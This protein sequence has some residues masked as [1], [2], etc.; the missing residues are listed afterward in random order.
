MAEIDYW[1]GKLITIR[2]INVG[3]QTIYREIFTQ[4]RTGSLPAVLFLWLAAFFAPGTLTAQDE[5]LNVLE[6][7]TEWSDAK[8]MLMRHL[9]QQAFEFLDRRDAAI[10]G[11]VSEADWKARQ[12]SVRET[13]LKTVGPFP[14]KTPLNARITGTLKEEGFRIEKVMYESMPGFPV[15]GCLYIPDGRGKKPAILFVS[16]HTNEAFRYPSYQ[17]M[18]LNLVKKGFIV[19][20]I[21]PVSQGERIQILDPEKHTSA[22]GPTTR[23]HNHLG[24]QTFLSGVSLARYFIWDGIRAVD[25]LLT[26]KEADPDRIGITGQSG[27]GTQTACIFAFDDRIKAAAVVNYITGFRR[28]LES[29]GP[30][31]AEQNFN[32]GIING[33]THADLLEVRAPAP[34]LISAG[35]RD[36]FSIQGARETFAE[37]RKT[38]AAFGKT[39]NLRMEEDDFGHGY[40]PL[41][42]EGIYD[43]FRTSLDHECLTKDEEVSVM[44][45]KA[46]WVT[47]SG[48][49][50]SSLE[51]IETVFTLNK[52]EA[53]QLLERLNNS[54]KEGKVHLDRVLTAAKTLSGYQEPETGEDPVFRGRYRR[55]GYSVEMYALKG[56]GRCVIPLLLFVPDGALKLPSMVWLH[57]QGKAVDARPGGRMEQLVKKGYVVAAPDLSG[58]GEVENSSYGAD[59]LSFMIGRSITG[60]QSGDAARVVRFLEA[61]NEVDNNRIEGVAF[62]EM[63]PVLLHAAAFTRKFS[64]ITLMGSLVSYGSVAMERLYDARFVNQ[65]VAGA[66]AAYDLPDLAASLAPANLRL[67]NPMAGNGK[68]TDSDDHDLRYLVSVYQAEAPEG[69]IQM[70]FRLTEE[71]A[72]SRMFNLLTGD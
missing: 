57:P 25:Y 6:R 62:G 60:I 46:L 31:D 29:I 63:G 28:L 34:V 58:T 50:A 1:I 72:C 70:I 13:L 47:S 69:R 5:N 42:R 68:M 61:R 44:D 71:D 26:R 27:G 39:E 33:L 11:L 15:T 52:K 2:N 20:A 4:K 51:N 37:V 10:S 35:T 49:T 54:R 16:G 53:G 8:T 56:E 66:L 48:Q 24:R 43:F 7:W 21:D 9:N 45:E 40:T 22:I 55:D 19:F 3:M 36:F 23:E 30:Q 59:Y 18:I 14:E 32:R 64:G 38:Y 67:I 41:L 17:V 12:Q 65:F